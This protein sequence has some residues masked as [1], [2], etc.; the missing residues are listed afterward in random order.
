MECNEQFL[1]FSF[2]NQETKTESGSTAG[3]STDKG[4]GYLSCEPRL[5]S[6]GWLHQESVRLSVCHVCSTLE[7]SDLHSSTGDE[8]VHTA[9]VGKLLIRK[10]RMDPIW[11]LSPACG[12]LIHRQESLV[13]KVALQSIGS[14]I[15]EQVS[16]LQWLSKDD[17]LAVPSKKYCS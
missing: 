15:G 9:K 13:W 4:E 10:L 12:I 5:H 17:F 7:T 14:L 11:Q 6:Y 8:Q 3:Q 2:F 1:L 16:P